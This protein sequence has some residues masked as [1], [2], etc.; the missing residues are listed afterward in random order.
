MIIEGW[1]GTNVIQKAEVEA[2]VKFFPKVLLYQEENKQNL[3]KNVHE[4]CIISPSI[5][6]TSNIIRRIT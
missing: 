5:S 3:M 6:S 1:I 4:G 2:T